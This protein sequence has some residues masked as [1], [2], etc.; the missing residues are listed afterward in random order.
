MKVGANV[1]CSGIVDGT[2]CGFELDPKFKVCPMCGTDFKAA[3]KPPLQPDVDVLCPSVN[4]GIPCRNKLNKKFRYC[5]QCG[6]EINKDIF[7]PNARIC[8]GEING[9]PCGNIL[10]PDAKFCGMCRKQQTQTSSNTG[11]ILLLVFSKLCH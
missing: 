8:T 6:W 5:D 10:K 4:D 9:M 3:P 11:K 1:K 2:P 7:L